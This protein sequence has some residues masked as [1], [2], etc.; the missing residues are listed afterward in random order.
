MEKYYNGLSYKNDIIGG[1]KDK[2]CFIARN[3][4]IALQIDVFQWITSASSRH[5]IARLRWRML[6]RATHELGRHG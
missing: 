3:S 6:L 2:I 5:V 1:S 4:G